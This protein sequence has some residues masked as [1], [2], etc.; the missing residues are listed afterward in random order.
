MG[1]SLEFLSSISSPNEFTIEKDLRLINAAFAAGAPSGAGLAG[2][3]AYWT[4]TETLSY[5]TLYWD[6]INHRLGVG[7]ASP[8]VALDI[9]GAIASTLNIKAGTNAGGA[10]EVSVNSADGNIGAFKAYDAGSMAWQLYRPAG[11]FHLRVQVNGNECLQIFDSTGNIQV[12]SLTDNGYKFEVNGT[13]NSIGNFS[14]AGTKFTVDASTGNITV[15]GTSTLS[16]DIIYAGS[17]LKIKANTASLSDNKI[18]FL[19]GGGD[20]FTSRGAT[21][22]VGGNQ[23]GFPGQIQLNPGNG[24]TG[25][26]QISMNPNQSTAFQIADSGGTHYLDID[27]TTGSERIKLSYPVKTVAAQES[28]GGGSA[29]LGANSPAV[30]LTAPYKWLTFITSDGSTV[31]I[32]AWK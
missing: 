20:T 29:L 21:I 15:A 11:K 7:V 26:V 3:V 28:T 14:V 9:A 25:A 10:V 8:I 16:G 30:T 5:D 31:Y 1:L 12:N 19:C 18:L 24:S 23:S 27:T 4:G 22:V 2:R 13:V 32:P 17:L 6:A